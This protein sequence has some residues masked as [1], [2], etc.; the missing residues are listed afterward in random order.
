VDVISSDRQALKIGSSKLV[1][2]GTDETLVR[3]AEFSLLPGRCQARALEA[4][5]RWSREAYNGSLQHRRD[6]WHRAKVPISRFDQFNEVPSSRDVCPEVA[7]FG[8]QPVRGAISRV[9]DAFAAFYRRT[10][11]GQ[12]PGYPRFKSLRRFRT[13]TYDEPINWALRG[14]GATNS[15]PRNHAQPALYLQGVGQIA[16][17]KKSVRQLMRLI[18]RGG[19]ARTLN[20]TKTASGAWRATVAFRGVS[21]ERLPRNDQV[22]GVDRGIWVTAALPDGTLLRCPPFLRQA[23]QE[24][25]PP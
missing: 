5:V 6:A 16:L 9:D 13:V 18:D 8:N 15:S 25:A 11:E 23:R 21:A 12:I 20:I 4:L 3:K 22:G 1:V 10:K 24:I 14:M 7:R 19:E 2:D 17:S